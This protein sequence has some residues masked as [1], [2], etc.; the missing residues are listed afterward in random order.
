MTTTSSPTSERLLRFLL[1]YLGSV[2]LVALIAVFMPYHWM[3]A[4]HRWLGLGA[5]PAAPVVGYLARTVSLIYALLGGLLWLCSFDLPRHRLVVRYLGAAFILFG[6]LALG[7][8]F[9]EGLPL[10]W[11]LVEGPIVIIFGILIL[12]FSAYDQADAAPRL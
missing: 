8:D 1:R 9:V 6:V 11:K 12:V 4:T 2:C 3:D 5:L 10:F 7:I